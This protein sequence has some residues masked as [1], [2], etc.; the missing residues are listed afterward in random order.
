MTLR[1]SNSNHIFRKGK[2][3]PSLLC[4]QQYWFWNGE[5]ER[6]RFENPEEKIYAK[7]RLESKGCKIRYLRAS[8]HPPYLSR[9]FANG[10]LY[11][12]S[13]KYIFHLPSTSKW[14]RG[15][16]KI[17]ISFG[18]DIKRIKNEKIS[19]NHQR[20]SRHWKFE[21]ANEKVFVSL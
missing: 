4:S 9:P 14:G 1:H 21:N 7:N 16:R 6:G 5:E 20:A 18:N 11:L 13:Q 8:N 15:R 2:F 19:K 3:L 12:F 10:K 17:E